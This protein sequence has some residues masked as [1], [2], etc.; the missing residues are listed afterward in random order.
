MLPRY[1]H[2]ALTKW[3]FKLLEPRAVPAA[4]TL[5]RLSRSH[6]ADEAAEAQG[7][8]IAGA[9]PPVPSSFSGW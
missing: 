8:S 3:K 7:G 2:V 4:F 5:H 9:R 1:G 6:S